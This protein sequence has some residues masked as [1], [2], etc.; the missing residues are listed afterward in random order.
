MSF[1][2][3]ALGKADHDRR[4]SEVPELRSY[5]RASRSPF[6]GVLRGLLLLC[7]LLIF[8]VFGYVTR[9][10]LE[11]TLFGQTR[12][13]LVGSPAPAI[14]EPVEVPA[15]NES[16]HTVAVAST[17]YD[18]FASKFELEVISYSESPAVR[19]V[20]INGSVIHEG[21]VLDTG[22]QLILIEPDAVVL[23][24]GDRE[25]RVGL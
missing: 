7:L 16:D 8:F 14:E 3:D 25:I 13:S 17:A 18:N 12:V 15:P 23:L 20:M 9:P 19:F 11:T 24:Q 10:Y 6:L 2:L 22:E 1:L 4:R 5:N 21:E